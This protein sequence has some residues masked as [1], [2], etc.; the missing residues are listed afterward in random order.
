MTNTI[1]ANKMDEKRKAEIRRFLA[2]STYEK[3]FK[4]SPL[5]EANDVWDYLVELLQEVDRLEEKL[6]LMTEQCINCKTCDALRYC[7]HAWSVNMENKTPPKEPE[8]KEEGVP[9][10]QCKKPMEQGEWDEGQP[11][12][13]CNSCKRG[14]VF[15]EEDD[16]YDKK[17]VVPD[18]N[19]MDQYEVLGRGESEPPKE[20]PKGGYEAYKYSEVVIQ[21]LKPVIQFTRQLSPRTEMMKILLKCQEDLERYRDGCEPKGSPVSPHPQCQKCIYRNTCDFPDNKIMPCSKYVEGE[22]KEEPKKV[23]AYSP[24]M[25]HPSEEPKEDGD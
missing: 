23:M 25:A 1:K 17:I 12:F 5:L 21:K 15:W 3:V 8:K 9:C 18:I 13:H 6:G 7:E 14:F 19:K 10:P 22:P 20:E 2:S 11:S 24:L 16:N 4:D